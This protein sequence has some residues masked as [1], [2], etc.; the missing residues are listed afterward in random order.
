MAQ[1]SKGNQMAWFHDEG[2]SAGFFHTYDRLQVGGQNNAPRKVHVFL[3]REYEISGERY[4]VVYM[5]DGQTAFFPGGAA[6]KSWRTA[7][8]LGTLYDANA[9]RKI[10][11]VAVHPLN[12]DIEYTHTPIPS[13]GGGGL[14]DY[15]QY[16]AD[17]LKPFIDRNYRTL[18]EARET[19]ILGSSHGG[20]AA[21]YIACRR[22]DRFGN[23]GAMSPSFWVGL[24]TGWTMFFPL[25]TSN[26]LDRTAPTLQN[27]TIRPRIWIDWGLVRTGGFHNS[28][29]EDR[30]TKRGREMAKLLC[31]KF[32]Y[33]R[34]RELFTCEDPQ[35][36][37]A[38]ESWSE[39]LP[40]VLKAFYSARCLG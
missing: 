16:M 33:E 36:V 17:C 28:W 27:K 35:G 32:G 34:D 4:P 13:I 5:N 29:I 11:V 31:S 30:A 20:L 14:E 18:S 8:V 25:A 1:F 24:D 22:C 26:L 39:R 12:R 9:I 21:F 15:T 38:E 2:H 7:E 40:L 19:T 6:V 3:P 37:H 10:I 23:A